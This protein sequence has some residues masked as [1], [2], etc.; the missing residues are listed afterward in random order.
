MYL[1]A[2]VARYSG[3]STS[4]ILFRKQ[5][6]CI[7][8]HTYVIPMNKLL[9]ADVFSFIADQCETALSMIVFSQGNTCMLPKVRGMH[10]L[11]LPSY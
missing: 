2:D 11:G 1:D 6:T 7:C 3:Y 10:Y 5:S 8:S 4:V 9:H